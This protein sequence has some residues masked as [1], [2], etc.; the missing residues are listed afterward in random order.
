MPF[1]LGGDWAERPKEKKTVK[2]FTEKRKG[3]ALTIVKNYDGDLKA[4][5]KTLKQHLSCG[6]TVKNEQ[7][8]LQ[9]DHV[10][11]VNDYLKHLKDL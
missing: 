8:E 5:A 10:Q 11:K 1:T 4:L 6:G 7:I 2:V 3:Q 9:G